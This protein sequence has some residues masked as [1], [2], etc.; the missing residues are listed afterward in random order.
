MNVVLHSA[1]QR[2]GHL[3][4]PSTILKLQVPPSCVILSITPRTPV[5]LLFQ[6]KPRL[7]RKI[8]TTVNTCVRSTSSL[9]FSTRIQHQVA[10]LAST[11]RTSRQ[12]VA[13]CFRRTSLLFAARTTLLKLRAD[14]HASRSSRWGILSTT[15]RATMNNAAKHVTRARD[16][17]RIR[18]TARGMLSPCAHTIDSHTG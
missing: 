16:R 6:E 10:H 13:H 15:S 2:R 17:T 4:T 8:Q 12:T 5:H 18:K 3:I 9:A 7:S 1:Q 14:E 11:S